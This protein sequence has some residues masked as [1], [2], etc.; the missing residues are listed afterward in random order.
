VGDVLILDYEI[1]TMFAN[2]RWSVSG[3]KIAHILTI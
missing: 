2:N 1:T 3:M